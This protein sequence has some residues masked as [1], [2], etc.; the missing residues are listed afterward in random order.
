M[1]MTPR[2]SPLLVALAVLP[3]IVATRIAVARQAA[4]AA[5]VIQADAAASH[6]GQEVCV[7]MVVR[8]ARSLADKDMCFLNSRRDHRDAETFTVVIFKPGL[9]RFGKAGIDNPALHFLDRKIR[10]R[11]TVGMHKDRPQIVVED[12]A[13]IELVDPEAGA[14]GNATAPPADAG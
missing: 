7:E 12:P 13:Q 2:L 9:E 3:G 6:V 14:A 1:T 8:A 4:V 5:N 10:V 11:G